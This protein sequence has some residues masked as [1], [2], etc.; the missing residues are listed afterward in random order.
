MAMALN[1]R[2]KV[3]LVKE[4]S[5]LDEENLKVIRE[6]AKGKGYQIWLEKVDKTGK[7]GFYFVDGE[8]ESINGEKVE[9]DYEVLEKE[10][11]KDEN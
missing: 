5:L 1:Y 4:A 3:I 7:M 10:E 8:I 11:V 2:L 9:T 6:M